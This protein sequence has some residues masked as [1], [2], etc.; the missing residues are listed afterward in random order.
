MNVIDRFFGIHESGSTL[1]REVLGGL[2]TFATMSYIVFVQ[3]TVL[4]IGGMPGGSVLLATC[5]ASAVACLL[6]GFVARYPFA[7]A[8]GMGENFFF[9][10]TIV[11]AMGFSWQAG[12]AIVF[13]AGL[14]FLLLSLFG[15]RERL[16][17]ILPDCLKNSIGPGIGMFIAFVGMQWGGII[18]L[19]PV[20]MVSLSDF[21][22]GVPL[23]TVVGVFLTAA[24]MALGVRVGILI[25]IL[26]TTALGLVTGI[27]P[28][29]ETGI[30]WSTETFFNLDFSELF[31]N[32][33]CALRAIALLFF[34]D[35]FDTIGTLV[36]VGKQAGYIGDDGKLPR[37][38]RA[39]FSD[40][41]AT[42][43]GALF[44]T[45]TVTTY[46]ESATGV[47]AGARTGLA[48]VVT[49]ICFVFAILLAPVVQVVGQDVGPAF[50]GVD[51]ASAHVA[52][53]PAV[54]PALIVV[55][56]LM[57]GSLR[58]I[59]WDDITESLPAFLTVAMMVFAY[60][61]HE[62]IAIGCISFV[63]IKAATSRFKEVHPVMYVVAALLVLRYAFLT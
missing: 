40:A 9:S 35:M 22:M 58:K 25:G 1:Q 51:P 32:W 34:M 49:G 19:D 63:A 52:M 33:G 62:G 30:E 60:A 53:Y 57:M 36:G 7:L 38:G 12:L 5:L 37:A 13:I 61:I 31:A 6:M 27:L 17:K 20:T 43:I 8:P 21:T 14:L 10:F 28:W 41:A 39:F 44:G 18:S 45:S 4:Q 54:A 16:M 59:A 46:V 48:A 23:I 3:P 2:T 42:C 29:P 50:Y 15:A 11:I 24:L 56:F 26:T 55:G 47:A